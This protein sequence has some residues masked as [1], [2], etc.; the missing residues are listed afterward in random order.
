MAERAVGNPTERF[1]G[2]PQK[3]AKIRG[4][5][6]GEFFLVRTR[7]PVADVSRAKLRRTT[8]LRGARGKRP[9]LL[10]PGC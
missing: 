6:E 5:A 3:L 1:L 2:Q 8:F 10:L 4:L 9:Q 7:G